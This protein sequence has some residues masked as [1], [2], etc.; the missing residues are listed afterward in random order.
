MVAWTGLAM[1]AVHEAVYLVAREEAARAES[2][3]ENRLHQRRKNSG[4]LLGK[5]MFETIL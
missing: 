4:A 2:K 3:E 5:A 1:V